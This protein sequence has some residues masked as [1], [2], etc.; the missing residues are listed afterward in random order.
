MDFVVAV[1]KNSRINLV[2]WAIVVLNQS[3]QVVFRQ[4]LKS[5]GK[6]N[7]KVQ[8]LEVWLFIIFIAKRAVKMKFVRAMAGQLHQPLRSL[9]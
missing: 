2:V 5:T 4:L 1:P 3:E 8:L 7:I 6:L 9:K